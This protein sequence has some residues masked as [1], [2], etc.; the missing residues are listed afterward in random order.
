[1][2]TSI[3]DVLRRLGDDGIERI[4]LKLSDLGGSWHSI[5]LDAERL[6]EDAFHHGISFEV[7]ASEAWPAALPRSLT[8]R[9]DPTTA[10]IDPFL[11]P[12][13]LSLIGSFQVPAGTVDGLRHCPRS[14][15]ARAMAHLGSTGLADGARFATE[16]DFFVFEEVTCHSDASGDGCRVIPGEP[17]PEAF[18]Q[19]LLLTLEALGIAVGPSSAP[20]A[21]PRQ[22]LALQSADL[23]RA[24]DNLMVARYVVRHGARRHG[25]TATFLPKPLPAPLCAGLAVH[26][27]LFKAGHPLFFGE[28]T[29]ADLS[30]TAR[31]YVGGL[32]HHG[33]S[34][35]AFSNCGTNSY[36]R[37]ASGPQAPTR[38]SYARHDPSTVIGVPPTGED[39][40]HRQVMARQGDGL[41]NPYLAFS[42]MLL[43][44]LDGLCRQLDPG[45]PCDR[46]AS[47]GAATPDRTAALPRD[48]TGSLD[49]L[50]ADHAYLLAGGVFPSEL[51]QH[52]IG[53]KRQEVEAVEE[54]PHPHEFSLHPNA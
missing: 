31:W 8:V 17:P 16:S 19:E 11:T 21:G 35:A 34:L 52:W 45:P 28:G 41:A 7:A 30:Q 53:T 32:L 2:A 44:G 10:W 26:Q 39:P 40:W 12:R 37:L 27:S 22:T 1:M 6:S 50:A 38:L 20:P 15:A 42:A 43:A 54:R 29:Y 47:A 48:L 23:L 46:E 25:R 49:A 3:Q 33:A 13:S 14:L 4:V 18:R 51:I 24:A 5:G 9:P 36:R